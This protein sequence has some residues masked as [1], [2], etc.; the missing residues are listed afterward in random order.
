[1]IDRSGADSRLFQILTALRE[2]GHAVTY[3]AR[4]TDGEIPYAANLTQLG[5]KIVAGDAERLRWAG[6]DLPSRW[7]FE[8]ILRD[9]DFD[10]AILFHWFW[11]GV[12]V[13]EDYLAE[14]QRLS[15]RTLA[16]VLTDDFHGLRERRAAELSGDP[17]DWER[18]FDFTAREFEVYRRADRC[19]C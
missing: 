15:P 9:G 19:S 8:T 2:D 7:N 10:L 4:S 11:S 1:M 12:S 3:L 16:A 13:A 5:I 14:I 18:S 6:E 17:A